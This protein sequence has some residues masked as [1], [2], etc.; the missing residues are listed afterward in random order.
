MLTH[1]SLSRASRSDEVTVPGVI[2]HGWNPSYIWNLTTTP[3]EFPDNQIRPYP[4]GHVLGAGTIISGLVMTSGVGPDYNARE[5]L[6]KEG[7]GWRDMLPYFV[8]TER[9]TLDLDNPTLE[10]Y[11]PW[12]P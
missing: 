11:H 9:F 12:Q 5:K 1:P 10:D 6:G 8:K 2:D 3:Q 4:A 7:W